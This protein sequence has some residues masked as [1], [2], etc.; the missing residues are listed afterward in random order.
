M[1]DRRDYRDL[2]RVLPGTALRPGLGGLLRPSGIRLFYSYRK[3]DANG[4][5]KKPLF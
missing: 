1:V 5:G 4:S 2:R 3:E